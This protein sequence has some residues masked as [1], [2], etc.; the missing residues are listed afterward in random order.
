MQE[1]IFTTVVLPVALALIMLG[2]GLSLKFEDFQ[3]ITKYPKAVAVGLTSQI[4]LLPI[5]G[6]GITQVVVMPPTIAVGL[7]MIAIAPG[8]VSSNMVTYLAGGDVALSVT[9]TVFSSLITIVTI[10][11]L[12]NLALNYFMGQNAT[13]SLPI[14]ATMG[15]IFLITIIPIAIGMYI[16]YQFPD[17]ARKL[18]KVTS[19]LA[20]A[21][22]ALIILILLIREWSRL[23]DFIVQAG[24]GVVLLNLCSMTAGFAI[25][26]LLN[27]NLPQQ[28]CVAV[29]V[30]IQNGTLAIAIT[31]GILG[32]Q[33]MAIP[34]AIY[35]LFMYLSGFAMILLG[36]NLSSKSEVV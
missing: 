15:Q 30:G 9:L 18:E 22:L 33:D 28:I 35:S 1:S 25:S 10:P 26:K 34:A 23:P 24:A 31:A 2:M 19:R 12:A 4:L 5:I 11:I 36:K 21:F 8:G 17:L 13:I 6:F 32:N 7:M 20:I 27:L 3:R 16:H 29:E 14:A